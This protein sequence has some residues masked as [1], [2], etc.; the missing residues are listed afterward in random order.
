VKI[1]VTGETQPTNINVN[2]GTPTRVIDVTNGFVTSVNGQTGAAIVPVSPRV[3]L[4]VASASAPAAV[5]AAADYVCDGTADNEQILAAYQAAKTAGGG[6]IT[7]TAGAFNLAA[8]LVLDGDDD[9]DTELDIS[10][11]GQGKSVTR[12]IAGAGVTSVIH[13]TGVVRVDIADL[14]LYIS[15][16]IHGITSA[17]TNGASSGHRSFWASSLKN[18]QIIGPWDGSHTGWAIN[19]G[20][21]FRSVWE[22]VE[23]GGVGNGIRLYSEHSDFNPGDCTFTRVFVDLKGDNGTAFEVASTTADGVMNQ[24]TFKVCEA[25]TDG[26]GCTGI[27]ITGVGGWGTSHTHWDNVNLE[28]FDRL[29]DVDRGSSNTFRLNHVGLRTGA[30]GLTAFTFG[31]N[32]FNNKI[33]HCG[34]FYATDTCKLYS[35][36]NTIEPSSPNQITNVRT[37][38]DNGVKITG[39]PNPA[40][41]TIRRG[42]LGNTWAKSPQEPFVYVPPG[43]GKRWFAARD[44]AGSGLARI[45]TVG[46]SATAGFYASNP[47]TKSWPGLLATTLQ[48]IYGDGGSGFQST[49][50]SPAILTG[51][52]PTALAAWQTAGAVV[53]QT[54]TWTQGGSFFGP[55]GHYLYTDVTGNTLT[56]KAR[57]TTVRIYTVVGGTTRPNM[58]YSI[59]GGSDVSVAQPTGTNAIQVTSITG[60]SNTEHTVVV[61]AGT[62]ST[63]QYLSVCGVSGEKAT[64]VL[65]HNLAVAGATSARYGTSYL[66]SGINATYNGGVDFPADL[67]IWSAAPN[68]ASA[69]NTADVWSANVARWI[70]A[71][72][73][74]SPAVGDVDIMIALPHFGRHEGTNFKYQDYMRAARG[75]ADVYGVAFVNW[76]GLGRNS[77]EYWKSLNYWGTNAGTGAAG[78]DSVHLSDAGFQAMADTILPLLLV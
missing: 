24:I 13:L 30:T 1:Q 69:N 43:W 63:G 14:G 71:I 42:L 19:C 73:D 53:G 48:S 57:G 62:A 76:W 60:L 29:I 72:R 45:V 6:D 74:N 50:L 39:S 7:L 68:D 11:H 67:C 26:T 54:G 20:S 55:S 22:N 33:E 23:I 32:S 31:A 64:G 2:G 41:T 46:G 36:S 52:D 58:L 70:R 51:S 8:Q 25:I 66:S 10:L 78:T 17:T 12:L 15:G 77:W 9:V 40:S 44:A 47:R 56:F 28:Q 65:V 18:F 35:D 5:K 61:K 27:R 21:A 3:A 34:L 16:G 75:L 49:A 4:T 59:D 38:G 37:Y